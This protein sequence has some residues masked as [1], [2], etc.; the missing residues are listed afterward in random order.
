MHLAAADPATETAP[1]TKPNG[2]PWRIGYLEG[3]PFYDYQAIFRAT[4]KAFQELGWLENRPIP[5][6]A[7]NQDN[8]PLWQWLASEGGDRFLTFVP[9]AYWSAQWDAEARKKNR[10]ASIERFTQKGDIDLVI[11]MGTWAGQDLATNEHRVSTIVV[12]SSDPVAAGIVKSASDSG[13]DHV[14]ARVDPHRFEQQIVM[15]HRIFGF[16]KMGIAY[17]DTQSGRSYAGLSDV[18]R[19]AAEKG[20]DVVPCHYVS[21]TSDEGLR[22][23]TLMACHTTLARKVDAMFVTTGGVELDKFPEILTPFFKQTIPTYSQTGSDEVRHGCLMSMAQVDFLP[24]GRFYAATAAKILNGASPR[25]LPQVFS[26][27]LK[28]AINL[29]TADIIGWRP[30]FEVLELADEI[31]HDIVTDES[32]DALYGGNGAQ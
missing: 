8:R 23:R 30:P 15:F 2:D 25:Q 27:P 3:G 4:L 11:A 24:V 9:D 18:N 6:P 28:L 12:S 19:V 31:Y 13:Y 29:K 21:D 22:F 7:D 26:E 10:Q 5:K 20:F 16:K 32:S 14:V 17:E 1:R